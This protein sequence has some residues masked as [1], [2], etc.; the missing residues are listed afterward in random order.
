MFVIPYEHQGISRQYFPDFIIKLELADKSVLNLIL[1]VTGKKDDKKIIKVKTAKDFWIPA[2]NNLGKYG[3]WAMLEIQD[4][5]ET[6]NL[7]QIGIRDGFD[8]I[9]KETLWQEKRK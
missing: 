9:A 5:H 2:M 4:I 7:I 1:E 3:Q 6:Q 8:N